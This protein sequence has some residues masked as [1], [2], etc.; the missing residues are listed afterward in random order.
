MDSIAVNGRALPI[1]LFLICLPP[2]AFGGFITFQLFFQN[3]WAMVFA[4]ESVDSLPLVIH[5]TASATFLCLGAMQVWPKFR[6]RNLIWHKR[7]GRIVFVAGIVGAVSG[8]WMTLI[9]TGI[10]GP[11]LFWGRFIAS[12]FWVVALI[13]AIYAISKRDIHNHQRWMIRAYAIALPAGSLAYIL[14]PL[15]LI[16]GEEG[17]DLMFEIVQVVAWPVHLAVAEWITRPKSPRTPDISMSEET[18]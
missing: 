3:D 8:L 7:A 16:F 11:I 5:A 9:H 15:V 2:T 18:I 1:V 10:S 13:L 4:A 14:F 12:G 6:N 17:N